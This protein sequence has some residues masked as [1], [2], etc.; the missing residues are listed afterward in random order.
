[1]SLLR[2]T[3]ECFSSSSCKLEPPLIRDR[4]TF[5]FPYFLLLFRVVR[6]SERR[7]L[8]LRLRRSS[9]TPVAS[10][11]YQEGRRAFLLLF[12]RLRTP[13]RCWKTIKTDHQAFLFS[14]IFG[15]APATSEV[16][17]RSSLYVLSYSS[18]NF[19]LTLDLGLQ[20]GD[21][22]SRVLELNFKI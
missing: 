16:P 8:L 17:N 7:G 1:M 12:G 19:W 18:I 21:L 4:I 10:D 2:F 20:F 9:A 5:N 14:P 22:S 15:E 6:L 13:P 3:P 11:G